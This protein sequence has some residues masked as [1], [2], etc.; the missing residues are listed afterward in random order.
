MDVLTHADLDALIHYRGGP[1]V[2]LY[3]PTHP[4]GPGTTPEDPATFKTV[5]T[6]ATRALEAWGLRRPDV[7]AII[8]P[9]LELDEATF[10]A[11]QDLGLAVFAAP[12]FVREYRL[13]AAFTVHSAVSDRFHLKPLLPLVEGERCLVLA[14]S[15]NS[16]RLLGAD[17]YGVRPVDLRNV[18]SSLEQALAFDDPEKQLQIRSGGAGST[19]HTAAFHGHGASLD[20]TDR[21]HRYLRMVDTG[22]QEVLRDERSPLVL[23]GVER[24]LAIY[25]SQ[26]SY[27][28]LL[29]EGIEGNPEQID[30][31]DLA[32]R[33]RE[34]ADPWFAAERAA[35]EAEYE[36]WAG[37]DRASAQLDRV[38]AAAH[39][40]RVESL[41]VAVG[42]Q[43]WGTIDA[44]VVTERPEPQPGDVDLLDEAA[45]ATWNTGGRVFAVAPD[46]VPQGA[47]ITAV[48][49]Y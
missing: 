3:L 48:F 15:Q 7:D 25:R 13:P 14:L 47:A 9:V 18:P 17:R 22:L 45:L 4:V 30:D 34:I 27:R 5:V 33:A 43:R 39:E 26:C 40:G 28:P 24:L 29:D 36:R 8:D 1:C 11:H 20:D 23:A 31:H 42:V 6:D 32:L 38:V 16:I 19:R 44:G 35:A 41:F 2:S 37:T 49:R 10:W 46:D 21:I 12:G